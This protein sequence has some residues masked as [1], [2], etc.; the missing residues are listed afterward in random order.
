LKDIELVKLSEPGNY[1]AESPHPKTELEYA[2]G[3]WKHRLRPTELKTR[4]LMSVDPALFTEIYS[5]LLKYNNG[6]IN[7]KGM[8]W[9]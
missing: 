2:A 9:N 3:L 1:I 8:L 4:V 7:V 6:L 5:A